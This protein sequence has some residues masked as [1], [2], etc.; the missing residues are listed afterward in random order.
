MAR[1]MWH[2]SELQA[3]RCPLCGLRDN[4]AQES[5]MQFHLTV[6]GEVV[7]IKGSSIS[8]LNLAI[9]RCRG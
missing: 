7:G 8:P 4:A 2:M 5:S 3:T 9:I 1:V 6:I